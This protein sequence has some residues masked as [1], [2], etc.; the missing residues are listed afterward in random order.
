MANDIII[1]F[2][3]EKDGTLKAIQS[4]AK[5]ASKSTEKLSKSTD[6]L[7][8][9]RNRYSKGEKGV[10]GLTSNSTKGFSKMRDAISGSGG[11][12]G[13]YATLA[14]NVFAVTA[15]FGVLQ[16]AAAVQQLEEGLVTIGQQSGIAM[17]SLSSGLK[18]ATGNAIAL[19]EAMRST[20]MVIGAGFD[21]STL[22][23]LGKVAKNASIALGR[24]TADSLARL[25]RGAVKLEPELLDELGIMVRL[26]EA[27]QEYGKSIGKSGAALTNF[28][29]RQAFMNAVLEQGEKKYAALNDKVQT[30]PYDQL[31]AAF[32]DLTK[33]LTTFANDT[34]KLSKFMQLLADNSLLLAGSLLLVGKNAIGAAIASLIPVVGNLSSSLASSAANA[35]TLSAEKAKL[36]ATT[37]EGTKS[38]NTYAQSLSEGTQ[39][40]KQFNTAMRY[41]NQ[42]LTSRFGHL[43]AHVKENGLF[44]KTTLTKAVGVKNAA[45][46]VDRLAMAEYKATVATKAHREEKIFGS[47]AAGNYGLAFKRLIVQ[48]RTYNTAAKSAM[49][50]STLLGKTFIFAG[51]AAKVASLSIRFL[52]AAFVAML[53][54]LGLII[55]AL[56]AIKYAAEALYSKFYETESLAEFTEQAEKTNEVLLELSGSLEAIP[57]IELFTDQAIARAN[58]L[59]TAVSELDKLIEKYGKT[60]IEPLDD[61]LMRNL[62]KLDA[63]SVFRP[64]F[65][66]PALL[67]KDME[68]Y[69]YSVADFVDLVGFET[70]AQRSTKSLETFLNSSESMAAA[71]KEVYKGKTLQEVLLG[72][73]GKFDYGLIKEIRDRVIEAERQKANAAAGFAN[74]SKAG[75][76]ALRNYYAEGITTTDLDEVTAAADDFAKA[77]AGAVEDSE[78]DKLIN[79]TEMATLKFYGL[80][81]VVGDMDALVFSPEMG[82]SMAHPVRDTEAYRAA[83]IAAVKATAEII[84]KDRD[85]ISL[86]KVIEANAKNLLNIEKKKFIFSGQAVAVAE[87]QNKLIEEQTLTLKAQERT[88][89][90]A[91]DAMTLEQQ[92]SLQ[93]LTLQEEIKE[94]KNRQLSL[95]EDIVTV[96]EKAIN[97]A[98]EQINLLNHQ[99]EARKFLLNIANKELAVRK[100]AMDQTRAETQ[101]AM[102]LF[103]A[104]QGRSITTAERATAAAEDP[105]L[106]RTGEGELQVNKAIEEEKIKAAKE[107]IALE[108]EL[109]KL[110]FDLE[111]KKVE[112]LEK[113]GVLT[114]EDASSLSSRLDEASGRVGAMQAAAEAAAVTKIEQEGKQALQNATILQMNAEREQQTQRLD[115]LRK[116]AEFLASKGRI[117]DSMQ[118][119]TLANQLEMS[120][121]QADLATETD[122]LAR[123]NLLNREIELTREL[124]ALEQQRIGIA[125]QEAIRLGAPEGMTSAITGVAQDTADPEGVMNQGTAGEKFAFLKE[126]TEG[127]MSELAQ[128]SPEGALMSS[129]AQGALQ[130]G[131]AFGNVF[132][133]ISSKGL[134][135]ETAMQAVGA[136]ISAIGAM[137]QAKANQAVSAIDK[138]IAAEKKRD[139]KSQASMAK[140]AALEKKKDN[141]KRKAFEQD[142][143]MKMGQTIMSTALAAMQAASAPPGLPYTLPNVAMAIAMGAA[144]LAAIS[145]TS[146]QGGGTASSEA[147]A[148]SVSVGSRRNTV[149]LGRATSPAGELA[150]ARGEAGIGTGM[151]NFRPTPAFTG[152]KYRANGGNTAFMVGEQGPELFVPDR[153]GS[154]V[155]SDEVPN[156]GNNINVN[157]SINAVDGPSVENM[158]LG[159]RGNIIGMIREA[160]NET[161]ETFLESVNVLSD[162]YQSER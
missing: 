129:I 103:A 93:G 162:Q 76:E 132:D 150:Y 134:T 47:I 42:S 72:P 30:S 61:K 28:E 39:N 17:R 48:V 141:I 15:A 80:R 84:K 9:S 82:K 147:S 71:F 26:D 116:E 148:S 87:A 32:S 159:Q 149:D 53:P 31:A 118:A 54:H 63:R 57:E 73:D 45:I 62:D 145:S 101:M 81:K 144:Q 117:E 55:L 22:E 127:F 92:Q 152:T 10:A 36:S 89:Q 155:P 135:M 94:L 130:M 83:L 107:R 86:G 38:V 68:Q 66:L 8:S 14:A 156:V 137:Q 109:L 146:Y 133:E 123:Q 25:T 126:Q 160:A 2:R 138:E 4:E 49:A 20:S 3:V 111:K 52:G 51:N 125:G 43:K 97:A 11:L 21:S 59:N 50:Q 99:Q 161:G 69:N 139:G 128:L 77:L 41:G 91:F 18:E 112:R 96:E 142:K 105:L 64:L 106:E 19:E 151:T 67:G 100:Q 154:I 108:F 121:V 70:T 90:R 13:A 40:T 23:R 136:T 37:I 143:K 65:R 24:D 27:T 75:A 102:E 153:Q 157:F 119:K 12:V 5:A 158:L 120:Q 113:E 88:K 114:P 74:A 104:Q 29:R 34:L 140:I 33:S 6:Q 60:D 98:Q 124:V 110:Q 16:R 46:A 35:A 56:G 131:E 7:S 78:L 58:A 79:E 44:N 95:A 122:P 1:K 85:R 115:F